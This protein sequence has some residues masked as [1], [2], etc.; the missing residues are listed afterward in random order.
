[1]S[2]RLTDLGG[3]LPSTDTENAP[4]VPVAMVGGAVVAD[5]RTPVALCLIVANDGRSC[6]I[7]WITARSA[8][9]RRSTSDNLSPVFL[10]LIGGSSGISRI[11]AHLILSALNKE[12]GFGLDGHGYQH[13]TVSL[14]AATPDPGARGAVAPWGRALVLRRI[15]PRRNLGQSIV[16]GPRIAPSAPTAR[17]P[18]ARGLHLRRLSSQNTMPNQNIRVDAPRV[19]CSVRDED[20]D[21]R[22][23]ILP[24][25]VGAPY[26]IVVTFR[27]RI[28]SQTIARIVLSDHVATIYWPAAGTLQR[29]SSEVMWLTTAIGIGELV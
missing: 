28:V 9:A 29:A 7:E 8:C 1:L 22:L 14:A 2:S 6:D 17:G 3:G 16:T 21:S 27:E 5:H 23:L 11:T 18:L 26:A 13:G 4:I 19:V 12:V 15:F 10:A 25:V 24:K 20:I